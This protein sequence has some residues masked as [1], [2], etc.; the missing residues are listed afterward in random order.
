MN[1]S[2][3]ITIFSYHCVFFPNW[4]S[5]WPTQINESQLLIYK[6]V[7]II[8]EWI[9]S[10]LCSSQKGLNYRC[11]SVILVRFI[12][13]QK[14]HSTCD[15]DNRHCCFPSRW[16]IT[17]YKA[18][19]NQR[20]TTSKTCPYV[21]DFL[22]CLEAGI[23]K[24]TTF[25]PQATCEQWFSKSL[26]IDLDNEHGLAYSIFVPVQTLQDICFTSY[27]TIRP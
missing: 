13:V 26:L 17:T 2:M 9:V 23:R 4:S 10:I 25:R 1:I 27:K 19:W 24:K 3:F 6:S 5:K 18:G 20:N 11:F 15:K 22:V 12:F 14:L 16:L 7:Q 8:L 21:K